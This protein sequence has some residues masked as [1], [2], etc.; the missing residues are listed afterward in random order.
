MAQNKQNAATQPSEEIFSMR[1]FRINGEY[2]FAS[3]GDEQILIGNKKDYNLPTM[4]AMKQAGAK[5]YATF[6]KE[7]TIDG[8]TYRRYKNVSIG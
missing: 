7:V 3:T 2:M 5:I 6:D 8:K 4:F 1:S